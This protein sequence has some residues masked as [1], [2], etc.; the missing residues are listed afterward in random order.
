MRDGAENA[1][2]KAHGSNSRGS[3]DVY[4]TTTSIRDDDVRRQSANEAHASQADVH[5]KCIG[6]VESCDLEEVNRIVDEQDVTTKCLNVEHLA[7]DHGAAEVRTSEAFPDADLLFTTL[8]EAQSFLDVGEL[9]VD[10]TG[11]ETL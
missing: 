1:D 3:P 7:G 11:R 9:T 2:D 10:S 8:L 4:S 5:G 6:S